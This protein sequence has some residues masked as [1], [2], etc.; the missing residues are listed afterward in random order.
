MSQKE[1]DTKIENLTKFETIPVYFKVEHRIDENRI[2][3][4]ENKEYDIIGYGDNKN[5]AKYS[6]KIQ[7]IEILIHTK[8]TLK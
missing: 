7:V 2:H 8:P 3:I 6:F 5:E 4:Y 1:V